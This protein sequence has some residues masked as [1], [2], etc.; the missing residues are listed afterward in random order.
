MQTLTIE[1]TYDMLP[2]YMKDKNE[3][4]YISEEEF[5]SIIKDGQFLDDVTLPTSQLIED[6]LLRYKEK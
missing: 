2:D 5:N 6:M 1:L 4:E 3:P